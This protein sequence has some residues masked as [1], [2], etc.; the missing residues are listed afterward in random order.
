MPE[1]LFYN[2]TAPGIILVINEAKARDNE[3]LLINASN[4][5]KKG[6]PKNYLP[7]ESIEQ[8]S[9]IIADLPAGG[10]ATGFILIV[11]ALILIL[12]IIVEYTSSVKMFPQFQSNN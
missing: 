3:I 9:E 10:D 6:K 8:I 4:L 2:T 7:D 11:G 1:N 5:F 12:I